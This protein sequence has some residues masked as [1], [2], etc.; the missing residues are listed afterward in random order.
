MIPAL[1]PVVRSR[2]TGAALARDPEV[3]MKFKVVEEEGRYEPSTMN[4]LE[5]ATHEACNMAFMLA[6]VIEDCNDATERREAIS[7]GVYKLLDFTRETKEIF[8]KLPTDLDQ[9]DGVRLP[10]RR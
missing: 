2:G 8:H 3:P 6:A 5:N 7:F 9:A 10:S 4:K 1:R